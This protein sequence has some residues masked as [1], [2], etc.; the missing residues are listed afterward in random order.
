MTKKKRY[1]RYSPEF[2]RE[3]TE[4]L[5]K[6]PRPP[7]CR[8]TW[9]SSMKAFVRFLYVLSWTAFLVSCGGGVAKEQ[10]WALA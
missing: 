8:H 7:S 1:K 10:R 4:D 6:D 9:T 2:K 3:A 5:P